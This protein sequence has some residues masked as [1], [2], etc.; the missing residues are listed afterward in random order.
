IVVRSVLSSAGDVLYAL[1][2]SGVT[3]LPVGRLKQFHRLAASPSD[4][5]AL[6]SFC[7]RNVITKSLTITDPGG[8]RTDFLISSNLTGVTISPS[9]GVTPATVQVRIDPNAFQNQN[10]TVTVPLTIAS[11]TAVNLPPTVRLLV[12]TRNPD[13]R[14]T[15]VN[16]PG[17]LVDLLADPARNRFY[18]LQQD[19]NQ[20]LVFDG[21]TYQQITALRTAT[22]PTQIAFTLDR[23]YL[24]IGHDNSQLAYVYDL[25]SLQQ[26]TSITFPPG[27]YPR[28]LASS[29]G[30]LLALVRNV[31]SDAPGMI[32]SVDFVTRRATALPSLGIYINSVNPSGVLTASPN[33]ASILAAMADGN[34]MLYDANANTFTVSRKDLAS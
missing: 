26:Q 19:R 8:G 32:D 2:D 27:H 33:G 18:I 3:V 34:V 24:L 13:Q 17:N 1:T 31:S 5:V 30:A 10:G 21:A 20:V 4:L 29:G 15:L 6:G 9:S 7:N 16:V 25:D 12:N 23:K 14:G 11:S 28:S 22:T